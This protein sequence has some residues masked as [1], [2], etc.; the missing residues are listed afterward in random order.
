MI[1][2]YKIS[3]A[4]NIFKADAIAATVAAESNVFVKGLDVTQHD[5][6]VAVIL[7][8]FVT[9]SHSVYFDLTLNVAIV[10]YLVKVLPYFALKN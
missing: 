5:S 4:T 6:G 10:V 3:K 1:V 9:M 8:H 7:E 2:V